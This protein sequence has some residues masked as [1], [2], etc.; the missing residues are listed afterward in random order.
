M[1]CFAIASRALRMPLAPDRD[2]LQTRPGVRKRQAV[3]PR[4]DLARAPKSVYKDK[5]SRLPDTYFTSNQALSGGMNNR[6]RTMVQGSGS[7]LPLTI[8]PFDA[9][10]DT[11]LKVISKLMSQVNH[12]SEIL[13][14]HRITFISSSPSPQHWKFLIFEI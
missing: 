12:R 1:P 6:P 3:P 10:C 2:F 14:W 5:V 13:F 4:P 11:R 7:Y 9:I 8:S